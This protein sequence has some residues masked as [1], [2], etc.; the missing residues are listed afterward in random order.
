MLFC[1]IFFSFF[2]PWAWERVRRVWQLWRHKLS[3]KSLLEQTKTPGKKK[4]NPENKRSIRKWTHMWNF[5][6]TDVIKNC[7][8]ILKAYEENCMICLLFQTKRIGK[9]LIK[10]YWNILLLF[11][12][13]LSQKSLRKTSHLYINYTQSQIYSDFFPS[14]F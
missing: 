12:N 13:L 10:F 11:S 5:L 14:W 7:H 6:Y 8:T 3:D 9:S 1:T 2:P 4:T